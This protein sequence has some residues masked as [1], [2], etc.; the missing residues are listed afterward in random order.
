MGQRT[1]TI[2]LHFI[3]I[4]QVFDHFY[5][6]LYPIDFFLVYLD[7]V[8]SFGTTDHR[9]SE[10]IRLGRFRRKYFIYIDANTSPYKYLSVKLIRTKL[11]VNLQLAY[12][13][14]LM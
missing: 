10:L 5:V 4:I 2:P 3:Y 14:H 11:R 12:D 6:L 1:K 9:N 8:Q 7:A 13:A